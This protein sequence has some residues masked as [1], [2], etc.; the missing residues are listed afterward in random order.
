[1]PD[2]AFQEYINAYNSKTPYFKKDYTSTSKIK[3]QE[4]E[5]KYTFEITSKTGREITQLAKFGDSETEVLLK[6]RT[7]F[8]I[9]NMTKTKDGGYHTIMEEI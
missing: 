7:N 8:N 3:G 6:P 4:F 9:L 1:M 2:D 5:G